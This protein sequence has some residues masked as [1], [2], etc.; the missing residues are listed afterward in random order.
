MKDKVKTHASVGTLKKKIIDMLAID[1]PNDIIYIYNGIRRHVKKKHKDC[2]EYMDKISD[3]IDSP[4]YV[5]IN[6]NEPNSVEF[7]KVFDKNIL[8]SINLSINTEDEYLYISSLYDISEA[9]LNNRINSGRLIKYV[10][11]GI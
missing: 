11:K 1:L 7:V 10:D 2:L 6:P 8:V 9:K 3:I 5:G 4:D